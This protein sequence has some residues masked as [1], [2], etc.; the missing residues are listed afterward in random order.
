MT[1]DINTASVAVAT[2]ADPSVPEA[3]FAALADRIT[4]SPRTLC[5]LLGIGMTTAYLLLESN[6]VR[7]VKIGKSRRI[8]V[9][10]VRQY[11]VRRLAAE[12][13]RPQAP[14]AQSAPEKRTGPRRRTPGAHARAPA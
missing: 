1:T 5:E 8:L 11:L 12:P 7:S 6:E 13:Q 4:V 14:G 2:G 9:E 3:C 10:S